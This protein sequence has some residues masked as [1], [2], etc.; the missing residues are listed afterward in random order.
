MVSGGMENWSYIVCLAK[1]AYEKSET[2]EKRA[3]ALR[4]IIFGHYVA[5]DG[6]STFE[7]YARHFIWANH[8]IYDPGALCILIHAFGGLPQRPMIEEGYTGWG[9]GTIQD[10]R[11][12]EEKR[13]D[14]IRT[15]FAYV[16]DN[17]E[18]DLKLF[19]K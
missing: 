4:C 17:A 3:I 8:K 14:L 9:T 2:A 1:K 16:E 6:P 12:C 18:I 19:A 15:A 13:S 7:D 11:E 10:L 5:T